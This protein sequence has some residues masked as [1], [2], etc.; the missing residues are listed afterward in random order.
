MPSAPAKKRRDDPAAR[1]S[2]TITTWF[3]VVAAILGVVL[4]IWPKLLPAGGPWVQL[5]LGALTLFF[6]FRARAIGTRG[7]EGYDGR[8][9][10]AAAMAGFVIMFFA[11][12]AAFSVLSALGA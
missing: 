8:V 12:N 7:V 3:A 10:L 2:M 6:A 9:S 11:G 1:R 4:I 5:V